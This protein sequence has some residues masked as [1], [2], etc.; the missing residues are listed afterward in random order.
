L[1]HVY[2]TSTTDISTH[3]HHKCSSSHTITKQKNKKVEADIR[4][5][6]GLLLGLFFVSV[7]G[8]IDAGVLRDNWDVVA[9]M[10]AGLVAFKAAV[11]IGLGPLFGLTRCVCCCCCCCLSLLLIFACC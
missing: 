6:R 7:G 10:L 3:P 11:N 4:P 1:S 9:W 2:T 8:S 5:F